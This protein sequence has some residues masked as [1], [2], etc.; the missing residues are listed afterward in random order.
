EKARSRLMRRRTK[1]AGD[2]VEVERAE[3]FRKMGEL[4]RVYGTRLSRGLSETTLPDY[5]QGPDARIT[6]PLDPTCTIQANA[7]GYFKRFRKAIRG[8]DHATRRLAATDRDLAYLDALADRLASATGPEEL[9]ALQGEVALLSSL[10]GSAGPAQRAGTSRRRDPLAPHRFRSS[11]GHEILVGRSTQG[12][13]YLTWR[14]GHPHDL[15]LHVQGRAGAHVIVRAKRDEQIPARTL[16]EAA[17]LA[18]YYSKARSETKVPVDYTRVKFLRR[19][20]G[21]KPGTALITQEKTILVRPDAALV[22]R[23]ALPPETR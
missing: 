11:D 10:P 13:A 4:L 20:R 9:A 19:P 2:L 1:I 12:N 5:Y 3:E 18:A 15:W 17:Q 7:E 6:I 22:G 21:G 14:L 23:L 16:R 8:R